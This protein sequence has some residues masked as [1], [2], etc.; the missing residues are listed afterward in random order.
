MLIKIESILD[1][2]A[3]SVDR[4]EGRSERVTD[5]RGLTVIVLGSVCAVL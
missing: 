3:V 2:S 5:K 1:Y 4:T